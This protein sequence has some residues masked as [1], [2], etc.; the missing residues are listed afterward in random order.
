MKKKITK[1]IAIL[2]FAA[3]C[4][5]G[6]TLSQNNEYKKFLELNKRALAEEGVPFNALTAP[7]NT[8]QYIWATLSAFLVTVPL[9]EDSLTNIGIHYAKIHYIVHI[10]LPNCS[11]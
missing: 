9:A 5:T 11:L 7:L 4:V 3:I 8:D 1:I 6:F 10:V 2:S